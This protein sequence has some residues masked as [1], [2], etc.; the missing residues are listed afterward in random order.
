MPSP[1]PGLGP[2]PDS[3]RVQITPPRAPP[4]AAAVAAHQIANQRRGK[5]G[6]AVGDSL[7]PALLDPAAGVRASCI[8]A[9]E[10]VGDKVPVWATAPE[11]SSNSYYFC[12]E[13]DAAAQ[14]A[15]RSRAVLLSL[16]VLTGVFYS[17]LAGWLAGWLS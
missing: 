16:V 8:I 13:S 1:T 9:G 6:R 10:A 3:L 17:V 2:C 15:R 7:T 14:L 12:G 5:G 11:D 4:G